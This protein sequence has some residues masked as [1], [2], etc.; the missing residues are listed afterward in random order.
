[1]I[2]NNSVVSDDWKID[3]NIYIYIYS[4]PAV[5]NAILFTPGVK[6]P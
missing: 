2:N 1:M 5:I 6:N 3:T 4:Y